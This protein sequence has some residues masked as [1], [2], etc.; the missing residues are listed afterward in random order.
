MS[1]MDANDEVHAL[2]VLEPTECSTSNMRI[3]ILILINM[4]RRDALDC[5]HDFAC[6]EYVLNL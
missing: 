3:L 1:V 4:K 5:L 6:V 2:L